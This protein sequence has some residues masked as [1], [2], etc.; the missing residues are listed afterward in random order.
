M[1]AGRKE[2][3]LI[4]SFF[5]LAYSNPTSFKSHFIPSLSLVMNV[6]SLLWVPD[7]VSEFHIIWLS[8]E[9]CGFLGLVTT[10]N[11]HPH[12]TPPE[13]LLTKLTSSLHSNE[14]NKCWE[15]G[16]PYNSCQKSF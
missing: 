15:P 14:E 8:S 1:N 11:P 4:N 10:P 7:T 6:P 13:R 3:S 5:H 12:P 2:G 9:C 16:S